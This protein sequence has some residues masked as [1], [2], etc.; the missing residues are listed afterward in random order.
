MKTILVINALNGTLP[1]VLRKKYP[2][3]TITCAEIFPFYK[4]HLLNL[5][6]AVA[7]WETLGDMKFDLIIGNPPYQNGGEKGGK[8]SLWRKI[9]AK[10]WTKLNPDGHM[11]MV[12]PQLPNHAEDLGH[13]FVNNQTK[14]VWTRIGHHFPGIGSSFYAWVIQNTPAVEPTLFIDDDVKVT[15]TSDK[16]PKNIHALSIIKKFREYPTQIPVTSSRQFSAG[17]V[18]DGKDDDLLNSKQTR[19]LKFRYRRTNGDNFDMWGSK[20]PDD[21]CSPKV[22]MTYS[23]YPGFTYHTKN[24]PIGTIR[25]MSGHVVVKNKKEA[26]SLIS[27]YETKPYS[28]VRDQISTGG[29]RTQRIYVQP[30]LPLDRIYTD[31]DVYSALGLDEKEIELIEQS[32]GR[33]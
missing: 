4:H 19:A 8:S 15:L 7:D 10:S 25:D 27:L 33:S 17:S 24:D 6:F 1:L 11:A 30:M 28:Y 26:D 9:V 3:A 12:V 29:M 20:E 14:V 22:T 5:G 23:G 31:G 18:A 2:S 13:I 16:L 21:Y 32:L